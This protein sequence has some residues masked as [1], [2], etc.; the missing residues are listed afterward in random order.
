MSVISNHGT[1]SPLQ[2]ISAIDDTAITT[3]NQD[4]T[5]SDIS[6]IHGYSMIS[7]ISAPFPNTN[8]VSNNS[9]N[10]NGN[11]NNSQNNHSNNI[12][13]SSN[14]NN[15]NTNSNIINNNDN[16]SNNN[17]NNNSNIHVYH[18]NL[19]STS[20]TP[21]ST[22]HPLLDNSSVEE[23]VA[24]SF[25]SDI[26]DDRLLLISQLRSHI[27]PEA[28]SLLYDA[29]YE[30]LDSIQNLDID[31]S[32]PDN[33]ITVTEKFM[34]RSW[35]PGH[36]KLIIQ[37][38][39][40]IQNS[41]YRID[42]NVHNLNNNLNE[43]QRYDNR[44]DDKINVASHVNT[45]SN[46]NVVS[47][48]YESQNNKLS[49]DN[50]NNNYDPHCSNDNENS[51]FS[52]NSSSSSS[53]DPS[54]SANNS[55]TNLRINNHIDNSNNNN[56]NNS[57]L[58]NS[59]HN[60]KNNSIESPNNNLHRKSRTTHSQIDYTEN[61]H[62]DINND[63]VILNRRN[64]SPTRIGLDDYTLSPHDNRKNTSS[65]N[66]PN[67]H[68][69]QR[70]NSLPL[71]NNIGSNGNIVNI[72]S[73]NGNGGN[74]HNNNNG[75]FSNNNSNQQHTFS[76]HPNRP[77]TPLT[78]S[79]PNSAE[80]CKRRKTI[81][82]TSTGMMQ[83][84]NTANM[85]YSAPHSANSS[86]KLYN[87]LSIP[88]SISS[89]LSN[90]HENRSI[91]NSRT[92]INNNGINQTIIP[93]P[94][95]AYQQVGT[96]T[97]QPMYDQHGSAIYHTPLKNSPIQ[98]TSLNINSINIP[99]NQ[100]ILPTSSLS[101]SVSPSNLS[102]NSHT[103]IDDRNIN[104]SESETNLLSRT[105]IKHLSESIIT[106]DLRRDID[107]HIGI[108]RSQTSGQLEGVFKCLICKSR[109]VTI[110]LRGGRQPQLS[111]V[112]SHLKTSKHLNALKQQQSL[113]QNHSLTMLNS[114][115]HHH[116]HQ[117]QHLHQI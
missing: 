11:P 65:K 43:L 19:R 97:L 3:H 53:E 35:K 36:K 111:N 85:I 86:P 62:N 17:L 88:T 105:L 82:T 95:T 44:Y 87:S 40:K 109:A 60:K 10:N 63:Q 113:E 84:I 116:Q 89:D 26:H 34:G 76:V 101:A 8:N 9:N 49:N 80:R 64:S 24:G 99:N 79:T 92:N 57:R 30:T 6:S 41:R 91:N 71:T 2:T 100:M 42:N 7:S 31:L 107:Y 90:Y 56:I 72:N 16:N 33:D 13:S 47:S 94:V 29:G 74:S 66:Y 21:I 14:T 54:S 106:K 58:N 59:Q 73:S 25:I 117:H 102:T 96:S 12:I 110:S 23:S 22:F 32:N 104:G 18:N 77:I 46:N 28:I 112:S 103:Y 70:Q 115:N 83:Q 48:K 55:I 98:G 37:Y 61:N 69:L 50:V 27:P 108:N 4:D 52:S 93:Q 51:S 38:V 45:R 78:S 67:L 15:N 68:V 39:K 20:T 81:S 5:H 1:I 75:N 114:Q